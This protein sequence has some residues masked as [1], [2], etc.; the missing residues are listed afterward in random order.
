MIRFRNFFTAALCV[1]MF[2]LAGHAQSQTIAISVTTTD[3]A[4]VTTQPA[5][6]V[7][8][9]ENDA[10]PTVEY[11][12]TLPG[13]NTPIDYA[14]GTQF[15]FV[16]AP[17]AP[18]PTGTTI[19][20]IRGAST[21]GDFVAVQGAGQIPPSGQTKAPGGGGAGG[22]ISGTVSS[23][24]VSYACAPDTLCD[25]AFGYEASGMVC[26]DGNNSLYAIHMG[27]G[28]VCVGPD[29][30]SITNTDD[31]NYKSLLS[32]GNL[33]I[34]NMAD[35]SNC[36]Y[37]YDSQTCFNGPGNANIYQFTNGSLTLGANMVEAGS[38]TLNG[39]T[40]DAAHLSV[41]DTGGTLLVNGSPIAG[42]GGVGPSSYTVFLSGGTVSA[43]N[44]TTGAVDYTDTD[45]GVVMRDVIGAMASTCGEIDVKGGAGTVYPINSLVQETAGGFSN[46]YGFAFPATADTNQYCQWRIKGEGNTP[47]IDQFATPVQTAG[48]I[49]SVTPT[50]VA[51]VATHS[52]I[53]GIWTQPSSVGPSIF[54]DSFDVR[55]PT[56]QRGCE[57]GIDLTEAL[58]TDYS[59][60][61]VDTDV[62]QASLAFPVQDSCTSWGSTDPG[63]LIG[64][65]TTT[66]QKEE[67]DIRRSFAIGADVAI[68]VR[69]EHTVMIN[70]YGLNC[71][72]AIDYGVRGG[73]I[74]PTSSWV[75]V[76]EATCAIGLVLGG[77]LASGSLLDISG[78]Y[79]EDAASG[80]FVPVA[81][82]GEVNDGNTTGRI[83]Y[84]RVVEGAGIMPLDTPFDGGGG[85]AFF[86][87][88]DFNLTYNNQKMT[89][90]GPATGHTL[91]INSALT[92]D[93][94]D[95]QI[96]NSGGNTTTASGQFGFS[97]DGSTGSGIGLFGT[98]TVSPFRGTV[99]YGANN[100]DN[101]DIVINARQA[102]GQILLYSGNALAA[103]FDTSHKLAVAV[104]ITAPVYATTTNC[105]NG[106]APAVCG[107]AAAGHVAVPTGSNPT[108]VVNTSAVT[109]NSEILLT[110]DESSTISGVTCNTT[111][112]TLP[113]PV[114]TARTAA[115]SFT[116]QVNAT[117][118]TNPACIGYSIVN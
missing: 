105:A 75:N 87:Q 22:G 51:S 18:W 38:L 21:T 16:S 61:S 103:T 3:Q 114:V 7:T 104:S 86:I 80:A 100:D 98:A 35:G 106:A 91:T 50:A 108:L 77:N 29:A 8:V 1:L 89:M 45:A 23:P 54:L 60:V 70:S 42:G 55:F 2:M 13:S 32:D 19:G 12:I 20:Y 111:L 63:G 99:L 107:S 24:F 85:S 46:Y 41:T 90:N 67:N 57:T 97:T 48:V 53:M 14:A 28:T 110:V 117:L 72:H 62:A 65:T 71:N 78:L 5:T 10:S 15:Q 93:E 36:A 112:S 116:I 49:F 66:S 52:K 6:F 92:D 64:F 109:A 40:S 59:N 115:T 102:S 113:T 96:N 83:S 118:L 56:N 81:H 94:T 79:F 37:N 58:N 34:T 76:G 68:D 43:Q 84:T 9:R 47:I 30:I 69:S 95:V 25:S 88:G 74:L 33:A 73:A 26:T 17:G 11:L 82:A 44:N 4:I 31:D 101:P 39:A 27:E